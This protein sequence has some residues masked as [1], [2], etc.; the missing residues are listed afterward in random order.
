MSDIRAPG[1]TTIERCVAA[2]QR[3]QL[4]I[5]SDAELTTDEQAIA[6]A[7]EVDPSICPPDELLRRFVR[8]ITF[9]EAR[10]QEAK[11][12]VGMLQARQRR[13]ATRAEGL[14]AE[15]FEVMSALDRQSFPAPFGTVSLRA[16]VQSVLI[17]DEKAIPAEYMKITASIDRTLIKDDLRQGVVIPGACL[18]NG[19]PTVALIRRGGAQAVEAEATED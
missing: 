13:Y 18:T 3:A 7:F 1:P 10:E 11:T 15:L 2:W 14:R 19:P 6:S 9:A 8:A 12:L 16:G 17:T 5:A 4:A